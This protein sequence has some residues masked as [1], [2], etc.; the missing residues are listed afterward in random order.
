MSILFILLALVALAGT[1]GVPKQ[2]NAASASSFGGTLGKFL[3]AGSINVSSLPTSQVTPTN[4]MK[5][6]PEL[7]HSNGNAANLASS[8]PRAISSKTAKG[9]L[10]QNFD[11]VNAIN[12]RFV[13]GFNLE[14]PD[15][16]LGVGK[17]Y[18]FNI[19]NLAG[20]IYTKNGTRVVGPFNLNTFF[21]EATTANLSDPRAYYDK[22]SDAWFATI[23]EYKLDAKGVLFTESHVDIAV[24]PSGDPTTTWTVYRIDTTNNGGVNPSDAGCPCL[25][26][27]P[28][29]GIDQYNVYISTNEFSANGA[30][31]NGAQLYAVSK[32]QLVSLSSTV[33]FAHFGSLSVGGTIAYRLQ[34]ATTY[35]N[36]PAEYF[37]NTLDPNG[38]FDNRL[39]VWALTNR[40]SIAT[41]VVPNLSATVIN[42]EAY[43]NTVNAQTPPGYNPGLKAPT[44]GLVDAGGDVMQEIEYINGHLVGAA[45]TS[46]TIAGE[47][48]ARDGIAWFD[49]TPNVSGGVIS[50]KT[51]ISKQG[52]LSLRGEYLLYPHIAR[53]ANG[54]AVVGFSYGGPGTYLSSAYA[55]M[56]AGSSSFGDV[57]TAASGAASDNGF[58]GTAARGGVGRWGDYSAGQL[59][60]TTNSLWFATQ[61]IAGTGTSLANWS[62]RVFEVKA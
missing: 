20:T 45:Q 10:L 6:T 35:G 37:M 21:K 40:A 28:I 3:A 42:S 48:A 29:F 1:F 43:A 11:G 17:N 26:D 38:T 19:V 55:I 4:V 52:Y 53:S 5:A 24:N 30:S 22:A 44:T 8:R 31:F 14:P 7:K 12:S 50:T 46:V 18:V 49:V 25:A 59:D 62:N 27:Y 61:Y 58:T 47:S 36:A 9:S 56:R 51:S 57:L 54:T 32:S 13:N 60:P 23:L 39:G 34:P 33:N 2:A 15:E 16:G 41:G